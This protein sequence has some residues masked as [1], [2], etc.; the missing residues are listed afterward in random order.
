MRPRNLLITALAVFAIAFGGWTSYRLASPPAEPTTATILP[1]PE[2]LPEFSLVDQH[3]NTVGPAVFE[4]QWDLLFFGFTHCPDICPLTLQ[5]LA[6]AKRRLAAAGHES[7]P[8][9]VFVSVDPDRDTPE[10]LGEYLDHFGD[11][12]LGL[13]GRLEELRKLTGEL[14]IYFEK[15]PAEGGDYTVD[16]SA[17]VLVV[18]PRGEFSALFGSPH[19]ADN[20]V[21][22]LPII[23]SGQ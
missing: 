4:G 10:K 23:M 3:G 13:T 9:I 19:S 12:I 15:V 8:R 1:A 20:Y 18:N 6:D 5:T 17:V 2:P 7:L 11:G 22:D 14:G 16:H 21:H